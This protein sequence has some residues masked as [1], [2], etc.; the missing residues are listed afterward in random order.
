MLGHQTPIPSQ[1]Q[2]NHIDGMVPYQRKKKMY[3][4]CLRIDGDNALR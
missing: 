1:V 3:N 2:H 4:L